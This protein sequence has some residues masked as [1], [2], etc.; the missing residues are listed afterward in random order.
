MQSQA[1]TVPYKFPDYRKTV[2]LHIAL[3][4]VRDIGKVIL[5]P[6]LP[7]AFRER[8]PAGRLK[9]PAGILPGDV[10]SLQELHLFLAPD[11]ASLPGINLKALPEWI[12]VSFGD[13][14]LA[15]S[16]RAIVNTRLHYVEHCMKV[17][18]AVGHR[19]EQARK[20]VKEAGQ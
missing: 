2:P 10:R 19:L 12:E 7:Y 1:Y 9:P 18:D 4:S 11:D 8:L 5:R 14:E 20:M 17:Y 3:N 15:E 13:K 6:R 16:I